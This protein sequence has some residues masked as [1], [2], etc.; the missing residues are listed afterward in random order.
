MLGRGRARWEGQNSRS[1]KFTVEKP[2]KYLSQVISEEFVLCFLT[3][4]ACSS[5]VG[6]SLMRQ[7]ELASEFKSYLSVSLGQS[8]NL[9]ESQFP[10]LQVGRGLECGD[11]CLPLESKCWRNL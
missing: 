11:I 4:P 5:T 3:L 6:G 7:E 1:C 2:D 8:L 10:H 9:I